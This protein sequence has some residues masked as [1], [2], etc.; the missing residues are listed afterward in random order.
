MTRRRN[1]SSFGRKLEL[2]S[3]FS[4]IQLWVSPKKSH[5]LTMS[6]F[7]IQW[8]PLNVISDKCIFGIPITDENYK[9]QWSPLNGIPD[10]GIIRLMGS[11]FL[12]YSRPYYNQSCKACVG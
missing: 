11:T 2:S 3:C 10:N 9:V 8:K 6:L 7:S 1:R 4:I 12:R 5:L